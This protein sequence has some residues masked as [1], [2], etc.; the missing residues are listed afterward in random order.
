MFPKFPKI[1]IVIPMNKEGPKIEAI[2]SR[3]I[4]LLPTGQTFWENFAKEF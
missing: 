1:G 3:P 2:K 4:S